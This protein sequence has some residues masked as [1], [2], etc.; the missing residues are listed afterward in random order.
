MR[1]KISIFLGESLCALGL[2]A[3]AFCFAL[4]IIGIPRSIVLDPDRMEIPAPYNYIYVI[5]PVPFFETTPD[6]AEFG[7]RS[8]LSFREAG[9]R[10]GKII[11]G[12]PHNSRE[13][14]VKLGGSRFLHW[15]E[16]G[17]DILYFST[18]NGSNP[19]TNG[20]KYLIDFKI[21]L[22]PRGALYSGIAAVFLFALGAGISGRPREFAFER[23]ISAKRLTERIREYLAVTVARSAWQAPLLLSAVG[24]IF[25]YFGPGIQWNAPL[26]PD[27]QTYVLIAKN[28][29][30]PWDTV[31]RESFSIWVTKLALIMFNDENWGMRV[32][33]TSFFL[34][35]SFLIFLIGRNAFDNFW[36]GVIGQTMF[37]SNAIV[38]SV[39][40]S[41]TRDGY[42]TFAIAGFVLC[43]FSKDKYVTARWRLIGLCVFFG[44]IVG[45][46]LTAAVPTLFILMLYVF[47]NRR[48]ID[49]LWVPIVV[50][51]VVTVPFLAESQ[52]K[53]GD[54][55]Y[56]S[57]IH[58]KWW[59]NYEFVVLKK[60]GCKGCPTLEEINKSTYAGENLTLNYYM[61]GLHDYRE[62]IKET[63]DGMRKIFFFPSQI[64]EELAISSRWSNKFIQKREFFILYLIGFV[65]VLFNAQWLLPASFFFWI[66]FLAYTVH[67][68]MP[69][70]LF[71][72]VA[73][74][75]SLLLGLGIAWAVKAI[76]SFVESTRRRG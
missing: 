68:Q 25:I 2:L 48:P 11:V 75:H 69:F 7:G 76:Y 46:R 54:M 31:P 45:V 52:L 42:F 16:D 37:L 8:R 71:S 51:L 30:H 39:G 55:M 61:F 22:E 56:S 27:V 41:A 32:V 40:L 15:G 34:A 10:D 9:R 72:Y 23:V 60:T 74:F 57:N 17:K 20:R 12:T 5:D 36:A 50:G 3:T 28:M 21:Y 49:F 35:T 1:E 64:W 19:K 24:A 70:R 47:I 29:S 13:D 14:V 53:T 65:I 58:A 43:L 66:N 44:I 38:F 33:G 4:S 6:T 18:T 67:I 59:R 62:L 26:Q 63:A 73:V